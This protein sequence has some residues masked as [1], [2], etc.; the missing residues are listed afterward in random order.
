MWPFNL[1]S[2]PKARGRQF[3]VAIV[4]GNKIGHLELTEDDGQ[5]NAHWRSKHFAIAETALGSNMWQVQ[6][7]AVGVVHLHDENEFV[8]TTAADIFW[9]DKHGRP[10]P[11]AQVLKQIQRHV[12]IGNFTS[13]SA[14]MNGQIL[15]APSSRPA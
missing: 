1:F 6:V 14:G 5:G 7:Q 4:D 2:K 11:T 3:I 12:S 8:E 9:P 13:L 15:A 10:L